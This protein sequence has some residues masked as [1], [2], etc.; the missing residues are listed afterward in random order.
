MFVKCQCNF[1]RCEVSVAE[2]SQSSAGGTGYEMRAGAIA[3]ILQ[4]FT[5]RAEK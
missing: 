3:F 2:D 4:L 5:W 1:R